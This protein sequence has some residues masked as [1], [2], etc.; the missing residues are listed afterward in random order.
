MNTDLNSFS[1][2]LPGL[3]RMLLGLVAGD[4]VV[5]QVDS[6][7]D[8]V[9]FVRAFWGEA[10]RQKRKLVYFRFARH[11]ELLR[12]EDGGKIVRLRPQDSFEQ[13]LTEILD[14]IE[15]EGL[16]ACY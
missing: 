2:G 10:K 16:G 4:N 13:F 12:P 14:V 9:P 11:R 5:W 15:R 3:D 8:Y 1:T 7:D 6:V